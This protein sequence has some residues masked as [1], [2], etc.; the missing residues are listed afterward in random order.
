ML[1]SKLI[2]QMKSSWSYSFLNEQ[3][4]A[5]FSLPH[6]QLSKDHA[7][8]IENQSNALSFS[9][10]TKMIITTKEIHRSIPSSYQGGFLIVEN[11]RLTFFLL[12]NYASN[13]EEYK[14]KTFH[15]EIDPSAKIAQ[16]AVIS[17]VNVRIGKNVII[18]ELVVIDENVTIKDNCIIRSGTIIG[19]TGFEFKNQNNN[20]FLIYHE[21][22]VIIEEDVELQ[23]HVVVD[24]A[25]YPY[26]ATIIGKNTKI[27]NFVHIAHAVKLGQSVMI[28]AGAIIAGRTI[29]GDNSWIGPGTVVSNGLTIGKHSKVNIGAVLI[30][31][32]PDDSAYSGNFAVDHKVFMKNMVQFKKGK[33]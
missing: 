17:K 32:I 3:D 28:A 33:N 15:S 13:L 20:L 27:D 8:F 26:D 10:K 11:P 29:I 19:G 6:N 25:I 18:G 7:I 30:N 9:E 1:I 24:K 12:H 5:Y 31:S 21:G 14:L 2:N 22:S 4:I 23:H 16:S